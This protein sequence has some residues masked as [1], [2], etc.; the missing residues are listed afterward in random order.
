M[1]NITVFATGDSNQV[2]TWSNVPYF[3]TSSLESKGIKVN[4][5]NLEPNR[6]MRSIF[7]YG[8]TFILKKIWKDTSYDYFRSVLHFAIVRNQIKKAI[9]KYPNSDA[10]AFLTF[11]FS[12]AGLTKK[13]TIQLCDWTYDY[14]F[15]YFKNR[16]PDF[17]EK[18]SIKRENTQIQETDYVISL[19][20]KVAD[21][22][23]A[24]YGAE[25]VHYLGN[26]INA[27]FEPEKEEIFQYKKDSGK[28]LF[29]GSK[30]YIEGAEA[31]IK[32][33]ELLKPVYPKLSLHLIGVEESN[34]KHL[35]ADVFCYGYLDKAIDAE[36]EKY[37]DLMKEAK[38]FINTTPKWA[39]FSASIEA[40]YYYTPVVVPPYGEFKTTFGEDIDFGLYC[41]ENTAPLIAQSIENILNNKQYETLCNQ[42][43]EA[44]KEFTWHGYIDKIIK[45]IN[46]T[47]FN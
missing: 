29:I 17:F 19:F 16:E 39:A 46:P 15:K 5:V 11:S 23:K 27:L 1:K 14:Y 47:I 40:M 12:S 44:V 24:Q 42:A 30:K 41:K 6:L 8:F 9:R 31:L 33:F 13:P 45:K 20:P 28:L 32:A 4:R 10:Y 34:F 38:I 36:K 43:H 21:Y 26:V 7:D 37:Y 2:K 25:K 22:M 35:P 3:F 18:Q